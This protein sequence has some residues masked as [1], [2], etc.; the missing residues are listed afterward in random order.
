MTRT[1]MLPLTGG[2]MLSVV[3]PFTQQDLTC[4]EPEQK[5]E[6]LNRD[7]LREGWVKAVMKEAGLDIQHYAADGNFAKK[8]KF[9][10]LPVWVSLLV[11]SVALRKEF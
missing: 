11:N 5:F 7:V 4:G 1:Q 9:P 2:D 6:E 10:G 3:S 8:K